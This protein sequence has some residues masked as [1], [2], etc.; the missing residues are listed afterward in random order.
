MSGFILQTQIRLA[1]PTATK[2]MLQRCRLIFRPH[3]YEEIIEDRTAQGL[4]GYP[5]CTRSKQKDTKGTKDTKDTRSKP[6]GA[7]VII[8]PH[9][10]SDRNRLAELRRALGSAGFKIRDSARVVMRAGDARTFAARD[11]GSTNPQTL[12]NFEKEFSSGLSIALIVSRENNKALSDEI[13]R[14]MK[15]VGP[16]DPEVARRD[17][18]D[19]LRAKFGTSRVRNAMYCSKDIARWRDD[20]QVLFPHLLGEGPA[21]RSITRSTETGRLQVEPSAKY[22]IDRNRGIWY[23]VSEGEPFCSTDCATSSA[24]FKRTLPDGPVYLRPVAASILKK[25]LKKE[26]ITIPKHKPSSASGNALVSL[27]VRELKGVENQQSS[28]PKS[29]KS[30]GSH[31]RDKVSKPESSEVAKAASSAPKAAPLSKKKKSLFASRRER[32]EDQE[33]KVEPGHSSAHMEK[34]ETGKR[35]DKSVAL[36]AT[37]SD[38][39]HVTLEAAAPETTVAT[40][41]EEGKWMA[42]ERGDLFDKPEDKA[43]IEHALRREREKL[44]ARFKE[45]FHSD[46]KTEKWKLFFGS[47]VTNRTDQYVKTGETAPAQDLASMREL[48]DNCAKVESFSNLIWPRVAELCNRLRL[49]NARKQI[50]EEFRRL[51]DTFSFPTIPSLTQTDG[52]YLAFAL[53]TL[54]SY[55]LPAVRTRLLG[56]TDTNLLAISIDVRARFVT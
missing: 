4:C 34:K 22:K 47:L 9:L 27:K 54:V 42:G 11:S 28:T 12:S 56:V 1:R 3:H 35:V 31:E 48:Q 29:P 14:L 52:E 10:V 17:C 18:P 39:G 7:L 51:M 45:Q 8:K 37:V 43:E 41:N 15:L 32:W 16:E 19:S 46:K 13:E 5:G 21:L 6:R 30:E 2:A 23:N 38:D 20:A 24:L 33:A 44:R 53:L 40:L 50:L 49:F 36:V 26:K 25:L 55:R